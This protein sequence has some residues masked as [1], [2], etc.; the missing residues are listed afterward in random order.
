LENAK[1]SKK[2]V[3]R[4][5]EIMIK[6]SFFPQLWLEFLSGSGSSGLPNEDWFSLGEKCYFLR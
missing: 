3:A 4:I 5:K 1:L 6:I 2:K